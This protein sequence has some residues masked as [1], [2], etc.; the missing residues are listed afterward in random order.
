MSQYN[1]FK[2]YIDIRIFYKPKNQNSKYI[3]IF[4]KKFVKNNKDKAK[5]IFNDL[6]YEL[7]SNF[8][9][10]DP[11]YDNKEGI[12]L[13]LR[14]FENITDMSEMYYECDGLYLFPD[15][16][17]NEEENID[18]NK[19]NSTHSKKQSTISKKLDSENNYSY[20]NQ[21]LDLL[22]TSNVTNMSG[23]YNESNSL[24]SFPDISK[25]DT[26]NVTDMSYM[27]YGCNSLIS[28]TDI[29]KWNT[30]NVTNISGM[31]NK[32]N[33]LISFPDISKLDISNVTDMSYMFY[34]CKL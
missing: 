11:N 28:L 23:M 13:K 21:F 20:N 32:S 3:Q 25:L 18:I 29:A 33:S 34:G 12:L 27:F 4:G 5:I 14:I 15:D 7:K 26:S 24:I 9:D 19:I 16:Y 6:E 30:S 22:N 2:K 17:N 10:I 8:R 31:Y 1:E